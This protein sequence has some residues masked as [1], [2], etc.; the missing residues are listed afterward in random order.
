MWDAHPASTGIPCCLAVAYKREART[1]SR[2]NIPGFMRQ[3]A[4]GPESVF[5][6]A[7]GAGERQHVADVLH[8][9]NVHDQPLKA[10][11]KACVRVGAIA[12]QI[13]IELI[14]LFAHASFGNALPQHFQAFLPL[15]AAD[16]LAHAGHQQIHGGH[17]FPVVVEAHVEGFEALGIVVHEH[18]LAKMF[19]A[20][21]ALVLG[22][23]VHAPGHGIFK[24]LAGGFE[25]VDG[26]GVGAA[27]ELAVGDVA[28]LVD[29]PLFHKAVQE[30]HFVRRFG[31]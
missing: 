30:V 23:Q 15:T 29:E 26:V 6:A 21:V 20:E 19:L 10:Q 24:R 25:D 18:R 16:E 8:A 7:R 28:Q 2:A 4:S 11:P 22:L 13:Q 1:K 27:G 5:R 14:I 31:H 12:P 17:G 9:G 3:R